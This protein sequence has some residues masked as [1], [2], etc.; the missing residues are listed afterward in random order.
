MT[1]VPY[2]G[3]P[4]I[5]DA[6]HEEEGNRGRW[7]EPS[8]TSQGSVAARES[9]PQLSRHHF[10]DGQFVR[11]PGPENGPLHDVGEELTA[12]GESAGRDFEEEVVDDIL[13]VAG[14]C[15]RWPR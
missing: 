10:G 11:I 3:R 15:G 14:A 7:K 5:F 9:S 1:G 6:R 4:F 2:R 13:V 8:S 12:E